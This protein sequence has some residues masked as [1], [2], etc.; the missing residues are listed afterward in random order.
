MPKHRYYLF[1]QW[2][3]VWI[4]LL[5]SG[6]AALWAQTA[7]LVPDTLPRSD[8]S[9]AKPRL[10]CW[11]IADQAHRGRIIGATATAVGGYG[12]TLA[13]LN[14]TWY[15]QY[16]RVPFHFFDDNAGW[17]QIDK[18]GHAWT[19]YIESYYT[20]E[21]Y[22]WAGV[23]H[24]PSAW[25]GAGAGFLFQAGLET[26]DGFSEGWGASVGDVAANTAGAL[27]MAGQMAAWN[28]Q[29]IWLKFSAKHQDYSQLPPEVQ[30]R[31]KN[32]YGST[33]P[34]RMLKDYNGQSYWLSVNPSAFMP[35]KTR[36]PKWL[37][38]AV[39]YGAGGMLG[40]ERN[41]WELPDGTMYDY[42]QWQRYR[43]YYLSVD[44]DLTRL[45]IRSRFWRTA[46]GMLNIIKI[47]APALEY[48]SKG[49]WKLHA[50]YW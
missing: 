1:A 50:L 40:A 47:P 5:L 26:L 25:I 21:L 43:Q 8:K 42:T 31:A 39:G 11:Q 9:T 6:T 14:Q 38:I 23:P 32:L 48:N 22:R 24:R 16:E 33:L 17:L 28:E 15:S 29:R 45:P 13:L 7:T 4:G 34:E 3:C 18:V 46:L 35:S 10:G 2:L 44:I 30:A 37:N 36:F 49:E 27:L 12:I 19:A 20:A 41:R